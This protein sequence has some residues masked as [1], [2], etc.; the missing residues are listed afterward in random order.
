MVV[1]QSEFARVRRLTTL[2]LGGGGEG[3]GEPG[4]YNTN[5]PARHRPGLTLRLAMWPA[6]AGG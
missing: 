6:L 4:L 3:A 2:P 1:G 5:D